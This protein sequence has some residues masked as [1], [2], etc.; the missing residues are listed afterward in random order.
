MRP[1]QPTTLD[2]VVRNLAVRTA[3]LERARPDALPGPPR[4]EE[5]AN[6]DGT[7]D[8]GDTLIYDDTTGIWTPGPGATGT[9]TPVALSNLSWARYQNTT[10]SSSGWS[11]AA[12]GGAAGTFELFGT[13]RG[14]M[15]VSRPVAIT[16]KIDTTGTADPTVVDYQCPAGYVTGEFITRRHV[17]KL[18]GDRYTD[19]YTWVGVALAGQQFYPHIYFAPASGGY[20]AMEMVAQEL[21]RRMV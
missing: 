8:D 20:S 5:L 11:L 7:A 16:F 21:P 13:T 18:Y 14:Q 15:T 19:V 3:R 6:V 9:G 17:M 10:G 4:V 2:G 12:S 1:P